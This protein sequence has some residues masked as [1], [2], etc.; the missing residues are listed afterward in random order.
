MISRRNFFIITILMSVVFFLCM[1]INNLK[2][3][4]ND[5]STNTF[6]TGTAEDYPSRVNIYVPESLRDGGESVKETAED[7]AGAGTVSVTRGKVVCIGD[8]KDMLQDVVKE[9]A[10]YTKR[11]AAGY[12]SIS[13]YEEAEKGRGHPEM[14]VID[15]AHIDWK[16]KKETEFLE[17]QAGQGTNLI[18][19]TLPDV[20]VI[21]SNR[22]LRELLGIRKVEQAETTVE[23][24]HL[25]GGFLL[26]GEMVYKTEKKEEQKFQ[27]ME[28]TFP[29]YKLTSGTKVY[30]KGIPGDEEVE[31]EDYPVL[32]WRKSC[33]PAYVFAVNGGYMQGVEGL[34]LLSAMSSEMY[35]YEIYPVVNAQN[36]ILAGF[37]GV[38]DENREELEKYYG[39]SLKLLYQENIWPA[40][41]TSLQDYQ[42]GV[43]CMMTPQYDYSDN[44]HPDP[45]QLKYYMKIL[46]EK[47][48]EIGLSGMNVSHTRVKEKLAKDQKFINEVAGNYEF[49]SFYAG[50]MD[51]R[52]IMAALQEDILSSVRTI[53]RGYDEEDASLLGYI[54]EYITEQKA[55]INGPEYTFSQDF[56]TRCL[57][58]ALGYLSM[59]CD[60]ERIAYPESDKDSW[61]ELAVEF[62]KNV[63][64]IGQSFD[65]FDKTTTAESDVRIRDFLALDY[66]ESQ[67]ENEIHLRT[68]GTDGTVWFI[69]RSY[70][71]TIKEVEGGSFKELEEGV[72]LIEAKSKD[73]TVI[74][75]PADERFYY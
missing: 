67:K 26:G 20:S 72:C 25:Y 57:E 31:K 16:N 23:G 75:E 68:N 6:V 32:V 54:S 30:M 62:V 38:A 22:Q 27:D 65:G 53:V 34:G 44:K 40:I 73:I 33:G 61:D 21:K 43:T 7:K 64:V 2:D 56:R 41:D 13:L 9:W 46:H 10:A 36:I 37:P 3:R 8:E 5:Y 28:L 51:Q 42:I 39:R 4:S 18:F 19:A 45:K 1:F 63:D 60:M 71:N 29:W 52:E 15:S 14:L 48:V 35:P 69:F 24:V 55:V 58:T 47:S 66:T 50:D 17:N 49:A 11:D 12:D 59:C 74:L 70:A